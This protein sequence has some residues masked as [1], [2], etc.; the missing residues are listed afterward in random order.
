MN[1]TSVQI[2]KEIERL[3]RDRAAAERLRMVSDMFETA[4][5]LAK[6]SFPVGLNEIELRKHLCARFYSDDVDVAA[7]TQAAQKRLGELLSRKP[8]RKSSIPVSRKR[9]V[10]KESPLAPLNR[11]PGAIEL[12]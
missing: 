6:A 5:K 4:R 1:D 11:Q 2:A 9:A 7:F 3:M 12:C 10:S 8:C